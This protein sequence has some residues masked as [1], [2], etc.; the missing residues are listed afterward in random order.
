MNQS[1]NSGIKIY[2]SLEKARRI[3]Q[4]LSKSAESVAKAAAEAAEKIAEEEI[5]NLDDSR[6]CTKKYQPNEP[7]DYGLDNTI[8]E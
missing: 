1:W 8:E 3:A 7:T 5:I 2:T 6:I 4:G